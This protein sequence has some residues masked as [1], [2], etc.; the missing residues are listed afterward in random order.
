MIYGIPLHINWNFTSLCN[1]NC[2]HCYSRNQGED[3]ELSTDQLLFIANKFAKARVLQ[4]NLGY[5]EPLMRKDC[6]RVIQFLAENHIEPVMTTNGSLISQA[7]AEKLKEVGLKKV[8]VS[9]DHVKAEYHDRLRNMPGSFQKAVKAVDRFVAQGIE[10]HLSTVVTKE[11]MNELGEFMDF[12]S[13][14]GIRSIHFKRFRP[15]GNGALNQQRLELDDAE[16][17][18]L[19][20]TMRE[21]RSTKKTDFV[22]TYSSNPFENL[23]SGC[24]CGKTSLTVRLNGDVAP[25]SYQ[26]SAIGN[27]LH[28]DL[29]DLWRHSEELKDFRNSGC[30]S[31]LKA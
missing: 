31:A 6:T 23:D 21:L 24:P 15:F 8:Y 1:F 25:C 28:D 14:K 27:L 13:G 5:G 16:G 7:N 17:D 29:I 12:F 2:D 10:T 26:S 30:C 22:F 9:V 19:R 4:V 11:N 3:K 18:M 20:T